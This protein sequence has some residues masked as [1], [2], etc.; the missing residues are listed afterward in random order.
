[1]GL[2]MLVFEISLGP[3]QDGIGVRANSVK[4]ARAAVAALEHLGVQ[5]VV[6]A[7]LALGDWLITSEA[8]AKRLHISYYKEF[9]D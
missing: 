8:E 7:P 6:H 9:V 2:L 4:E 3:Y 1:M 5:D